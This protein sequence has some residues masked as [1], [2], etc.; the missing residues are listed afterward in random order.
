MYEN[1]LNNGIKI[2]FCIPVYN[3][4]KYLNECIKSIIDNARGLQY[5]II[6]IDDAS[7][8]N[9]FDVLQALR[10]SL[11]QICLYK[12]NT[13]RGV[14]Y[15]RNRLISLAK[16]DYIWFVDPDDMLYPGAA[17][18]MLN[19]IENNDADIIL[20][21]YIRCNEEDIYSDFEPDKN[22]PFFKYV[23]YEDTDFLPKDDCNLSMNAIWGS[24][25]RRNFLSSCK[26]SFQEN[27]IAQEDTLFYYELSLKLNSA[28]KY[29]G[30][31][32]IYRQRQTSVMHSRNPERAKKYYLSILIMHEEYSNHFYAGNYRNEKILLDK[33]HHTSQNIATS[34]AGIPDTKYVKKELSSLKKS[35]LYPYRFRTEALKTSEN[36]LRRILFYLQPIEPFFWILHFIYKIKFKMYTS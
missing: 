1:V 15:T 21:N 9:S 13:N 2:S 24:L 27:M 14:G 25:F 30:P 6:C 32:Y 34:L 29:T 5:E 28:V 11:P 26:L 20:G 7:T 18:R 12:N 23:S 8:D 16:G 35:G 17:V 33:M 22:P 36:I 19:A 4:S 3:V 31:C 10:Q